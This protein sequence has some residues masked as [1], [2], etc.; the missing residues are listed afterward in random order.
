MFVEDVDDNEWDLEGYQLLLELQVQGPQFAFLE[1]AKEAR[2]VGPTQQAF[3][4]S[5]SSLDVL[6]DHLGL[7][8]VVLTPNQLDARSVVL[9]RAKR[10]V[11]TSMHV[12]KKCPGYLQDIPTAPVVLDEREALDLTGAE[13]RLEAPKIS[14]LRT[15]KGVDALIVVPNDRYDARPTRRS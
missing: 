14:R 1:A 10:L 7:R 5:E 8:Y 6:G 9:G 11:L 15:S 2:K 13:L 4:F 12:I 3:G